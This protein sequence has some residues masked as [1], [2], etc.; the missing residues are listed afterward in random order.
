MS[1]KIETENK[2]NWIDS[3]DVFSNSWSRLG[4]H[5][6]LP[7]MFGLIGAIILVYFYA[8]TFPTSDFNLIYFEGYW[9]SLFGNYSGQEYITLT[10]GREVLTSKAY[11]YFT[12]KILENISTFVVLFSTG[13][14]ST[15]IVALYLKIKISKK[16]SEKYLED[17]FLKGTN[18]LTELALTLIQKRDKI[19][20]AIIGNTAKLD[21]NLECSHTFISGSSGTG[22]TVLL[23][24]LYFWQKKN[25]PNGKWIIHDTKAD[26]IEKFF[27]SETD[28]IFNFSDTR[29]LNFNVFSMIK[30]IP[31]IK[32]I[33]ATIIPRPEGEKD[34]IWS[35]TA[36]DLLEACLLHCIKYDNKFN[37]AVKKLITMSKIDLIKQLENVEGAE[38]AYGHLTA[39]DTQ[40]DNF[41]S[42]FRGK[43]QFFT[44]LPDNLDGKE[45]DIEKWINSKGQSTIFLLNDTK[46]KDLN[47]IRIAVF[48]DSFIKTFLSMSEDKERRVYF[49]LDELGSLAKI[50]AI[51][52]GLA[53]LRSFGGSFFIGI[54]EI[55]RLYSIYGK[56]L[57][58]TIVNNTANKVILR[59][60]EVETQEFCSK[61]IGEIKFKSSS[62]TNSTG[63]QIEASREGASFN[64]SEKTEKAVLPSEI[65]NMK[66]NTYYYKNGSYDW[67]FIEKV[68]THK[69]TFEKINVAF[70]ER[71]DLGIENLFKK[72]ELK[73]E[74]EENTESEEDSNEE[75]EEPK[76]NSAPSNWI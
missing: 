54:Q 12:N 56:D 75:T 53:L 26:W 25:R 43:A 73:S 13:F 62:I 48:V 27:N 30:T 8:S 76:F 55:Q 19:K 41:M 63:S 60:Q 33:V 67:T 2:F 46:N 57:T 51:V 21:E 61:Q 64:S 40:G 70:Q 5:L 20:G 23:N 17:Q 71:T 38:V 49:I 59:A 3:S 24:Q 45:L 28:Y 69:D 68:F 66:N 52:D 14:I 47:A 44:T 39:G 9:K 58:S 32:S 18:I 72:K 1:E 6:F 74:A 65:G 22:K 7:S 29:S 4:K 15:A 35:D 50:P 11:P 42:N 37:S 31:D 16:H 34:P 10:G 36:R